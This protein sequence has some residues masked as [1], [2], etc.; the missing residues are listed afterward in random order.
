MVRSR[1]R[2]EHALMLDTNN[3]EI[4]ANEDQLDR[5]SA[6]R[7][8]ALIQGHW[9]AGVIGAL[10]RLKIVDH[11]GEDTLQAAELAAATGVQ[12][13]TIG[14]LLRAATFLGVLEQPDAGRFA[15]A[16][17]AAGLRSGGRTFRELAIA[18]T[19]PGVWRAWERLPDALA[20]SDATAGGKAGS[21]LWEHFARHPEER[22]RFAA[23]MGSMSARHTESVLEVADPTHFRRIVDV[24]GSHGALLSGLLAA[25]PG[26]TGVLLDLPATIA[27][28]RQTLPGS[29]TAER[30]E[31]VAGDFFEAVPV[32]GDLYLLKGVLLDWN[33]TDAARILANC[34][35]AAAHQARIWVIEALLPEPP[36]TSWVNLLDLNMLALFGGRDR[37]L[38]EYQAL[39]SRAGWQPCGVTPLADDHALIEARKP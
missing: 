15:A 20:G 16:P 37:T 11:L 22:A 21:Q 7:L 8:L 25:A 6:F 2:D 24:G 3:T 33:D 5:E 34:H 12:E 35:A 38:A 4:R 13:T 18:L 14:R 31:P 26:A 1:S 39:L 10:A 19:D 27:D 30:I 36:T 17:I 23:A 9:A 29:P 28:A 32:G